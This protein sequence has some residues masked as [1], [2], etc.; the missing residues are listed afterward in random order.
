MDDRDHRPGEEASPT[1]PTPEG[2]RE[3][4]KLLDLARYKVGQRLYWV[5]FRVEHPPEFDRAED[6]M[7]A[8]HPWMLWRRKIIPWNV[9][10]RPPRAHPGDTMAILMLCSQ[11][12][13]IEP[14][15]IVEVRRSADSGTFLYKGP[16]GIVMPEGLLFPTKAAARREIARIAKV[17]AA[18]AGT[19]DTG[20]ADSH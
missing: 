15:R 10:M 4:V 11:K 6:W 13:K 19:W 18:W 17:F 16:K 8:E 5:V 3:K 1:P 7:K 14:F 12:P 20:T 2:R 9:P